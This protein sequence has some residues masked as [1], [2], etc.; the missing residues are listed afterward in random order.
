MRLRTS[1]NLAGFKFKRWQLLLLILL[2]CITVAYSFE[3]SRM[4]PFWDE[5]VHLV[6]GF[7]LYQGHFDEYAMFTRYPPLVDALTAGSFAVFGVSVASARLVSVMFSLL[8]LVVVFAFANKA[9]NRKAAFVACIF[10]ATMPGFIYQARFALL[11]IPM[12]FFFVTAILLFYSWLKS[13]KTSTLIIAGLVF[14]TA[15]LAKHQAIVAVL[16]MLAALPWLF[17]RN[18]T[19]KAKISRFPLIILS[20]AIIILPMLYWIYISGIFWQWI[21]LIQ[22]SDMLT[23]AYSARFP[24]PVFYLIEMTM[25]YNYLHPIYLPIFALGLAGLGFMLWRKSPEDKLLLVWFAV[26][27]VFFT[28]VGTKHWRYVM[29]VF[30]V[31]AMAAANLLVVVYGKLAGIWRSAQTPINHKRL[32]KVVTGLLVAFSVVAV[33]ASSIDAYTLSAAIPYIALPETVHYVSDHLEAN[34]SIMIICATNLVNQKATLFYLNAYEQ[35]T[36][37]VLV[38]PLD[39]ADVYTPNFNTTILASQCR[40]SNVAYLILFENRGEPYYNTTLTVHDVVE[41]MRNTGEINYETTMGS[42]PCRLFIFHTNQTA[43]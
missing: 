24:Q 43:T 21:N 10:L 17:Y 41:M 28:L 2:A 5:T 32:V 31:L 7:M 4:G 12:I 27:Y 20:S 13:G 3:L 29:P 42:W 1:V 30:P 33:I 9:Y 39:P 19:F 6:G 40:A 37:P 18:R 38:Y 36:N 34:Q 26:I 11:D 16:V 22:N 23:N 15:T 14:G 8:I 25:P 35:K